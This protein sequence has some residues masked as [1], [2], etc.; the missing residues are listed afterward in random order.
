MVWNKPRHVWQW[1][2]LLT[3]AVAAVIASEI[4]KWWSPPVP[5]LHLPNGLD[6]PNVEGRVFQI[7]WVSLKVIAVGSGV[8]AFILSRGEEMRE[9]IA[10]VVFFTLCL[11]FSNIFVAFCGCASLGVTNLRSDEMVLM[12]PDSRVVKSP[13]KP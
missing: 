2:L 1:L 7:S 8:I 5:P 4:I 10:Q 3:P 6:V 11:G 9:R 12:P 13:A